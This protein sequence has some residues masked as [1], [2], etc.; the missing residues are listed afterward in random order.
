V[1][2]PQRGS[3]DFA[4]QVEPRFDSGD[5]EDAATLP[6]LVNRANVMP[7]AVQFLRRYPVQVFVQLARD[8]GYCELS[9]N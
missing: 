8:D 9:R 6:F 1:L 3:I 5:G 4:K 7:A 2:R